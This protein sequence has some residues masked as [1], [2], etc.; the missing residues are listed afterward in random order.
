MVLRWCKVGLGMQGG[1]VVF[2]MCIYEIGHAF[3]WISGVAAN[4]QGRSRSL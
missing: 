3:E 2:R 4:R 1:A